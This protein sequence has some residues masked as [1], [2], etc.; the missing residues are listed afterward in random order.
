MGLLA[1]FGL[2]AVILLSTPVNKDSVRPPERIALWEGAAPVGDGAFAAT[3]AFI[4]VHFPAQTNGTAVV[5]CPGGGYGAIGLGAE[6]DGTAQWLAKNGMVGVVLEYRLPYGNPAI[7]LL[8]AQRAI[9]RVRSKATEWGCDPHRIGILGFSAGGHLAATASTHF[10]AGDP[11]SA[12]PVRR[13][14]SRPDFS[15]LIY[16]VITMGPLTDTG[17]RQNLL[18]PNPSAEWIEE[19]SNEK[20]VTDQ[21][22]PA[23]LIHARDDRIVSSANSELYLNAL[24]DRQIPADYLEMP[25]GGHG[26]GY[27]GPLWAVWQTRV[28]DWLNRLDQEPN[29]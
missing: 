4:T 14:S 6:G 7:P 21:T 26:L 12:D 25:S 13:T 24:Q 18:G 27:G 29:S 2:I 23:F 10:D 15:I 28:L 1:A 19:Y 8:D 9:R 16:P 22:P 20:Q 17:T 11:S 5:V 3:G